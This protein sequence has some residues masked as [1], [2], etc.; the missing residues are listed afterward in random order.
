MSPLHASLVLRLALAGPITARLFASTR[1]RGA[2]WVVKPIDVY[3]AELEEQAGRKRRPRT[4][5]FDVPEPALRGTRQLVRAG[6]PRGRFR[7]GCTAP[8]A[9]GPGQVE[10]L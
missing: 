8:E 3:P 1:G 2:D 7:R 10:A 5:D 9:M 4:E 6:P